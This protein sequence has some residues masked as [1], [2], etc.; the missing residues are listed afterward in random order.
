[1]RIWGGDGGYLERDGCD[2]AIRLGLIT[3]ALNLNHNA[4]N[5]KDADAVFAEGNGEWDLGK[6]KTKQCANVLSRIPAWHSVN[7]RLIR[8]NDSPEFITSCEQ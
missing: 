7:E 3:K 2:L 5:S 8:G 4:A 1:M 6:L